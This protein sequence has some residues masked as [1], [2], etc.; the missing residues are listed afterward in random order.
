MSNR[1]PT[2]GRTYKRHILG[3][4][5]WRLERRLV[6]DATDT[7]VLYEVLFDQSTGT[8]VEQEPIRQ[9]VSIKNWN[10]WAR[11]AR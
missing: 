2:I 9:Q 3:D 11:L 1:C 6:L 8:V 7:H 10:I 4:S 5:S